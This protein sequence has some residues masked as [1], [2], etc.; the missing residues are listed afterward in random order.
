[1]R[2]GFEEDEKCP[3]CGQRDD[4]RHFGGCSNVKL[5]KERERIIGNMKTGMRSEG[6]N[7]FFVDWFIK[8]IH[9]ETPGWEEVSPLG[10]NQT[11]KRAYEDQTSIGWGNFLRG[12]VSD[13]M[14]NVQ[15]KWNGEFGEKGMRKE[16]QVQ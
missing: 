10:L 9:G 1:M 8:V 7:P 3:L 14:I 15:A 13:R 2:Y 16:T 11:V 6:V 12:R 4:R 5:K